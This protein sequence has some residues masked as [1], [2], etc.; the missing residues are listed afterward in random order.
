M[1]K[2]WACLLL[3]ASFIC[4]KTHS[5]SGA[6][7]PGTYGLG[8]SYACH[9][10][11]NCNDVIGCS[12]SCLRGWSGPKCNKEN[13]ALDKGTNQNS[14]WETWM[15]SA[16]AVDGS[17]KTRF[18]YNSCIHTAGGRPFTWWKVDLAEDYYIHKLAIY[19][20]RDNTGR[21]NGVKVY[22]SVDVNQTNTGH[23]CGSATLDS[24]DVTWMTCDNTS[25]YITLYQD[26]YNE[27]TRDTA[28]DFCEVQVFVCDAG[29]FGDNCTMFCHC[30]DGPCNYVTGECSGGCKPNWTGHTCS[31]CDS[32]HYGHLCE[33]SCSNKHC[34]GSCNKLTGQC[35]N[36]CTAGWMELDCTKKCSE[37]TYGFQCAN[38]CN[39]RNCLG[40]SSCDHVAGTCDQGCDR[41]YQGEDC[42]TKCDVGNYGPDCNSS[43][44]ARRCKA[45]DESCDHVTG[46]CSG[47]C[48]A[49]WQGVDCTLSIAQTAAPNENPGPII[50]GVIGTAAVVVVVVVAV[51]IFVFL[52]RRKQAKDDTKAGEPIV[53]EHKPSTKERQH[54]AP[55]FS[56]YVNVELSSS[57]SAKRFEVNETFASDEVPTV[58]TGDVALV[59]DQGES[60][61]QQPD[62]DEEDIQDLNTYYNEDQPAAPSFSLPEEGFDV[63]ELE[64]IIES[65]RNQPGG[66][67]AEY[68]HVN[69]QN[70]IRLQP[71]DLSVNKDY[72]D[73]LHLNNIK[74]VFVPACCTDRLQPLDL[75]VNKDYKDK[76]H[77]NNI[78]CVFVPACCTDYNH[79]ICQRIRITKTNY[80]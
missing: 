75:S 43:C 22:S 3:V 44:S 69:V 68:V 39:Q 48:E 64:G 52:R 66:F 4:F 10:S 49:G 50:G 53:P 46:L 11:T 31:E 55:D 42:A 67:Q 80:I 78:K 18:Q 17:L 19:F 37:S 74:C 25:R 76:L 30:Q 12:G 8:C 36:G 38:N 21:R 26:T 62:E 71:L 79:S 15:K 28:M 63:T 54:H 61:I 70:N 20:R 35:E 7:T 13:I 72:K 59:V 34:N 24:P 77:L 27:R 14:Y 58:N 60:E 47:P 2:C 65:I 56:A 73:E 6:C 40:N 29:T 51:I 45:N 41:G 9:C 5:V 23:L 16:R 33:N 1:S 57:N 32:N